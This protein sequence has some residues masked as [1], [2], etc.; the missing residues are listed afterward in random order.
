MVPAAMAEE[1]VVQR[2]ELLWN[3]AKEHRDDTVNTEQ[4]LMAIYEGNH[5]AFSYANVS[6]LK[7]GAILDIPTSEQA[8]NY[9]PTEA[10]QLLKEHI[11]DWN[12]GIKVAFSGEVAKQ[13]APK[14]PAVDRVAI[15]NA[16]IKEIQNEINTVISII[17]ES[18][19]SLNNDVIKLYQASE[20]NQIDIDADEQAIVI[21]P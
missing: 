5:H 10:K 21:S 15:I 1:Y 2:G 8:G 14:A 4:M 7:A 9:P 3:I 6:S 17:D 18:Q 16:K 19:Q 12:E 11:K 20:S 13:D